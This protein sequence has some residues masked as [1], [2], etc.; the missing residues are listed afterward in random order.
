[1]RFYISDTYNSAMIPAP[2]IEPS[3]NYLGFTD[4]T[5]TDYKTKGFVTWYKINCKM[6][7]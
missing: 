4:V 6:L 1:M 3:L 5:A 2:T 7:T